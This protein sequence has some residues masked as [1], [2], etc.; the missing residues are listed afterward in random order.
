MRTGFRRHRARWLLLGALL[1]P[2]L[3]LAVR[4]LARPRLWASPTQAFRLRCAEGGCDSVGRISLGNGVDA[5]LFRQAD[6]DDN[7]TQWA[8]CL[9]TALSCFADSLSPRCVAA[10]ACPRKCKQRYERDTAGIRD[11]LDYLALFEKHFVEPGGSC[12]P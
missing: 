9:E 7:I 11:S 8:S 12:A 5:T 4:Y 6:V 3:G 1:I 2:G 10:A